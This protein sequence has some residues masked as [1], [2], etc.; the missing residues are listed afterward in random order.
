M[1]I[2]IILG[3]LVTPWVLAVIVGLGQG[4]SDLIKDI[5]D[6]KNKEV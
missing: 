4:T 6:E 2:L 3:L 5:K 1:I